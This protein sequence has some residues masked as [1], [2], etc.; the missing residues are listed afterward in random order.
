[1]TRI[2]VSLDT[3]SGLEPIELAIRDLVIAGW[4]G[5]DRAAVEAHIQEL[6]AVGV[7]PP[8]RTPIFYRV[9][10]SLLTTAGEIQV[11]GRD[12]SGEAEFVLVRHG[13]RLLLGLG[14]DHTDRK[15]EAAGVALSKQLCPKIMAPEV[16]DFVDV[17]RHWDRLVLRSFVVEGSRL[18]LY[19][20]GAVSQIVHPCTLLDCYGAAA[21]AMFCGTL[22]AIGGVRWSGEFSMELEDPVLRRTLRHRYTV[23]PLPVET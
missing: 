14:S 15:A 21:D 1:M 19:Q 11:L 4:T 9:S 8:S 22:A 17:E 3:A 13:G 7:A 18:A 2:S 23:E 12:S 20:E 6:A 16:W 5:R 10:A